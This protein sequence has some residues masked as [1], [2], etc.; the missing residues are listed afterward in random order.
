MALV[1]QG[2]V[3]DGERLLASRWPEAVAV[4]DPDLALYSAF[5][6]G[7]GSLR[8]VLGPATWIAGLRALRKGHLVGR[9]KGD[10]LVMPG[11]FLV[12][13]DRILWRHV[14]AHSGDEPETGSMVEDVRAAL[15]AH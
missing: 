6:L 4:S 5:G 14:F 8:Q 12:A 2:S 1:H 7:R 13:G 11:L 3:E 9:P 10:T 15:A